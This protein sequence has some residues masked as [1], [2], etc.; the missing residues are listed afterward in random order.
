MQVVGNGLLLPN[1][2]LA[3][4]YLLEAAARVGC[5]RLVFASNT[6]VVEGH[7]ADRPITSDMPVMPASLYGA[8][9]CYGEALCALYASQH[10]LST[11]V[12]RLGVFGLPDDHDWQ[13]TRELGTWLSPRDAVQLLHRAIEVEG[14]RHLV[15]HGISDNRGRRLDLDETRR[16][17]GYQPLDG[18][19]RDPHPHRPKPVIRNPGSGERPSSWMAIHS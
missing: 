13:R 11:I 4:T 3:T 16:V 2:I 12:L 9:K 1:N 18:S 15:A 17:L 19:S 10:G 14:V 5:K 8:S 6:Q 7:A